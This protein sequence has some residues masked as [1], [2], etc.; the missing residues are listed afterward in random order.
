[1]VE[2]KKASVNKES[3]FTHESLPL[4]S[5]IT[6]QAAGEDVTRDFE[7]MKFMIKVNDA[8]CAAKSASGSNVQDIFAEHLA[9]PK[10]LFKPL[11]LVGPSGAGK[12]TLM[13]EVFKKYRERFG[14][15]VSYTTRAPR[16]GEINGKH[17]HFVDHATFQGKIDR[18]EFIEY[19][20]VH[21]NLYGSEKAQIVDFKQQKLIALFD[22]DI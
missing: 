7:K 14:F 3:V 18:D 10:V 13:N 12:G 6:E 22:I 4:F 1:M 16:E 9:A 20:H 15:S 2:V 21:T 8:I 5:G 19:C 11:A 17:Y